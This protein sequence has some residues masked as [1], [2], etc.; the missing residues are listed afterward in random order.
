[1]RLRKKQI[2]INQ[3]NRSHENETEFV[4]AGGFAPPTD[5]RLS[6]RYE[7]LDFPVFW[8]IEHGE[9]GTNGGT[10]PHRGQTLSSDGGF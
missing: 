10:G 3:T 9:R 6:P 8:P 4:P 2:P 5:Q 7:L 1:M